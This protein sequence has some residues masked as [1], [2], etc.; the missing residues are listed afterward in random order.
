MSLKNKKDVSGEV[1][2]GD[3]HIIISWNVMGYVRAPATAAL[4]AL[5]CYEAIKGNIQ[6]S[7]DLCNQL[8]G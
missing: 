4:D 7:L 6:K 8:H 5:V 1:V 3:S 2:G